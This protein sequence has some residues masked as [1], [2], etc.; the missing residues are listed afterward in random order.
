MT[1]STEINACFFILQK[2]LN[3]FS[4]SSW[5]YYRQSV[6][7]IFHAFGL[8]MREENTRL[9]THFVHGCIQGTSSSQA[10]PDDGTYVGTSD[11][12]PTRSCADKLVHIVWCVEA[13]ASAHHDNVQEVPHNHQGWTTITNTSCDTSLHYSLVTS[14]QALLPIISRMYEG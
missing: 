2:S 11:S 13:F 9:Y 3:A 8:Y 4:F 7:F 5:K 1:N 10:T 6:H 14:G 12:K